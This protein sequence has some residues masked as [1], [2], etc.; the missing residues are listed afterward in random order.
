M[1]IQRINRAFGPESMTRRYCLAQDLLG[2]RNYIACV[3][4]KTFI[5]WKGMTY[6]SGRCCRAPRKSP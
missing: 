4:D 3:N 1:S 6:H 5:A 2:S